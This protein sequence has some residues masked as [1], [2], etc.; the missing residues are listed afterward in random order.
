MHRV[1]RGGLV[2]YFVRKILSSFIIFS[3]VD[4]PQN[5]VLSIIPILRCGYACITENCV[6]EVFF[7]RKTPGCFKTHWSL[8]Q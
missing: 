2:G 8:Y 1:G 4:F 7:F 5:D 6:S 3:R